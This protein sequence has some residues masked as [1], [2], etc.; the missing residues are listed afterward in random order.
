MPRQRGNG[1][2]YRGKRSAQHSGLDSP[3]ELAACLGYDWKGNRIR[4]SREGNTVR[5]LVDTNNWISHVVAEADGTGTLRAFYTRGGDGLI[6]MDQSNIR[7][8]H[9]RDSPY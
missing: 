1:A 8:P 9:I 6:A 2:A 7:H 3:E 4:K 5:Y